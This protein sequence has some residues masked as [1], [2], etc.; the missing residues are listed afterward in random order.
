VSELDALRSVNFDWT[1]QLR[2]IWRDPPYHVA[3]LHHVLLDDLV[4]YF[5]RKT[6]EPD[7]ADEPL[8]RLVVGPAGYGKTHL[9]GELRRRVW[10]MNGWFVLLDFVG[11]K[12]FWTS[13]ALGLLN[14]LQV[15]MPDGKLQYDRLVLKIASLL[16]IHDEMLAIANRRRRNSHK[17]VTELAEL[18]IRSLSRLHF[19]ET[20]AHRD[21][22]TALILLNSEDLDCHSVAHAWL[23]GMNLDATDANPLGLVG[24]NEPIKVVQGLSWLM[25]LVG[26]TL[27]AVDQIDAIVSASNGMTHAA[28]NG[29]SQEQQ[30]AQSIVNSL[31]EG[32]MD[33]HE[34][35][36]RA[37]IV[38]S[39]LEAT[40]KV[41]QDKTTVA[42]TDRYGSPTSLHALPS[43][44]VAREL[45][46]TR[47]RLAYSSFGFNPP[48][49]T[50]PFKEAALESAVG[51][52]PRELLRVCDEHRQCCLS[53]GK[54][55]ECETLRSDER[56]A[57]PSPPETEQFDQAYVEE[58]KKTAVDGL[59]D[60]ERENDLRDLIDAVLRLLPKHFN[61]PE[62]IDVVVQRDPDQKR[63]S[64]H[65]RLS[66]TFRDQG[67]REQHY[68]FLGLGHSNAFA[69]QSRLKAAMTASGI[70]KAL[71][72]RHLFILRRGD[73]PG[74]AKTKALVDQFTKAGGKFIAPT[75]DDLRSLVSLRAMAE[76]NK[77]GFEAWLRTRK[78]LFRTT[79]FKAA[80]LSLSL[81][82]MQLC[83]REGTAE[84]AS[85][86]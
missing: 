48:Y 35:K 4:D 23:Q 51:L 27:I 43:F 40:W 72:F 60:S 84:P 77:P 63:P 12:D 74:G 30:E 41:L 16:D 57:E 24:D 79:F 15:R 85:Q 81:S 83:D 65:G 73:T 11:I 50:W 1:R 6:G 56:W 13:V 55:I 68:C 38:V 82:E 19:Q 32:L 76:E 37:V 64:L 18:F 52:S 5:A 17:L 42:V 31:A 26:P 58:I 36:R 34:K 21:V 71:K 86:R 44:D 7:P 25:S 14:S 9:I 61:L 3:S 49:P 29:A 47:L 69:F 45:V 54:V 22:V 28:I 39:C 75:D 59:L 33:L 8:G 10:A 80:V 70:D 53:Q 2:S 78:P 20:S 67:D 62:N 66:F 46:A